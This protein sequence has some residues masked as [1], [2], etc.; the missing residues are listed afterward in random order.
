M[1]L[2][3]VWQPLEDEDQ[4]TAMI[5]GFLRHAP[6]EHGLSPWLSEV[7]GGPVVATALEPEN[8]WPGYQSHMPGRTSTFPEIVFKAEDD[9][10]PFHVIVEAK[11]GSGMHTVEQLAREVVDTAHE[12]P[13][14]RM[15]LIAVGADLGVPVEH[16]QWQAAVS[17]ALAEH[18]PPGAQATVHYSSW[19]QLGGQVEATAEAVPALAVYA[20]D[21]LTQMRFKGM[22]GYKGAPVYDDLEGGLN[23]VNSFEVVNRAAIAARQFYRF[24]HDTTA[25]RA[26]GLTS[27]WNRFEMRRNGTSVSLNQDEQWF[28]VTMF[29][30]AYKKPGW[31]DGA[32]AFATVYF[33]GEAEPLLQVGAF[34]TTWNELLVEYDNSE[35]TDALDNQHLTAYAGPDLPI[36]AAGDN[37]EWLYDERPWL[38]AQQD[39]D[40][41]WAVQRL[42][43]AA[44]VF[45]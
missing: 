9:N 6:V 22:L 27:Y 32:G 1:K 10:G 35:L 15:A 23:I 17:S 3:S 42:Q 36:K 33:A 12:E 41:P 8:F 44:T 20:K 31:P 5:F 30:S 2:Y 28:E 18:G 16:P 38:P 37:S 24:L 4:R 25:F 7:L 43:A 29:M 26:T 11:I 45:D 34:A 40:L 13:A 14:T 39:A 21:V 19:A